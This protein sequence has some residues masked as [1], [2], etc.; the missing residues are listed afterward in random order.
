MIVLSELCHSHELDKLS[1][2]DRAQLEI[3]VEAL[4]KFQERN[5][6]YQDLWKEGGWGDSAHHVRHKAA[7]VAMCL[8]GSKNEDG[9]YSSGD[10]VHLVDLEE[11]AIDLINYSVFFVRNVRRAEAG[12]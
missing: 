4:N 12:A 1:G 2:T 11:D 3:L 6:K 5:A 9:H 8:R 7:R 10:P